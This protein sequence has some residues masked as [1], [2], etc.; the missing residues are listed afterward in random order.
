MTDGFDDSEQLE[1]ERQ[2]E[3]PSPG[4]DFL[5]SLTLREPRSN[6]TRTAQYPQ[7]F[8][9]NSKYIVDNWDQMM[10]LRPFSIA[11]P[12]VIGKILNPTI[13][14][15]LRIAQ[16]SSSFFLTI[17][18]IFPFQDAPAQTTVLIRNCPWNI[19]FSIIVKH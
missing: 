12:G 19:P 1:A 18:E 10:I 15:R 3:S 14:G 6:P 4:Y 7:E 5:C 8:P 11:I 13:C 9:I 2:I 16:K 17:P